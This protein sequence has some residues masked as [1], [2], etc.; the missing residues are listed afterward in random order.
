MKTALWVEEGLVR[1]PIVYS[2]C[3]YRYRCREHSK[4][5]RA[6]Q[7]N[8]RPVGGE[9]LRQRKVGESPSEKSWTSLQSET[10]AER[11]A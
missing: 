6:R 4:E 8:Q 5:I 7:C 3:Y 11:D 2:C 9:M 1:V 10:E